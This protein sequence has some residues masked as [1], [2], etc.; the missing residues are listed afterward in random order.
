TLHNFDREVL[1]MS[2]FFD[3]L[4]TMLG[5]EDEGAV[6][7]FCRVTKERVN[8]LEDHPM[9]AEV[10]NNPPQNT[11]LSQC[12]KVTASYRLLPED[13][14]MSI[15]R[16]RTQLDKSVLNDRYS[17]SPVGTEGGGDGVSFKHARKSIHEDAI[18]KV[19]DERY[20]LD[21]RIDLVASAV[22][23]LAPVVK[24]MEEHNRQLEE[25]RNGLPSERLQ[26]KIDKRCLGTLHL[27]A[28]S[29]VYG[30]GTQEMFEILRK[31]PC[32]ALPV[33]V[34]RLHQKEVEWRA[35]RTRANKSW[36][37]T[38]KY[39]Y[40]KSLDKRSAHQKNE[41]KKRTSNKFFL[42]DIKER[43]ARQL[44]LEQ[45]PKPF[46]SS[47]PEP[48]VA[49]PLAFLSADA[50]SSSAD[51]L[52]GKAGP[53]V[54]PSPGPG[55]DKDSQELDTRE[56][57][58]DADMGEAGGGAGVP[59]KEEDDE[60]EL[61]GI[62]KGK[63]KP[64]AQF[65][66]DSASSSSSSSKK[67]QNEY[68][69]DMDMEAVS[70]EDKEAEEV[71]AH[72][73]AVKAA[74]SAV[75]ERTTAETSAPHYMF[76]HI[77]LKLPP[78]SV[79]KDIH[80]LIVHAVNCNTSPVDRNK[81]LRALPL[82]RYWLGGDADWDSGRDNVSEC[83]QFKKMPQAVLLEGEVV[84]T[85]TPKGSGLPPP[86]LPSFSDDSSNEKT[87]GGK[88]PGSKGAAKGKPAETW[89]GSKDTKGAAED[90]GAG[91]SAPRH[92]Q[93]VEAGAGAKNMDGGRPGCR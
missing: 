58:E 53:E 41:D 15:C 85:G 36:E 32:G 74:E 92:A 24:E 28:I 34:R 82:L 75:L 12:P 76:S 47:L 81:V 6:R 83:F 39:S 4:H 54:P 48:S 35:F 37:A 67:F 19:E 31:N 79:Q 90:L 49:S 21:M 33:I 8:T 70:E 43:R 27:L 50:A 56:T 88:G 72:G 44:A 64:K 71:L 3:Q 68:E 9:R 16:E 80:Q 77:R 45:A 62:V 26:Y 22:K 42:A 69:D 52:R 89:E 93:G 29:K 7:E 14:P 55:A 91:P 17:S 38:Q 13:Y 57:V 78:R 1:T 5:E 86:S 25:G 73:N 65:K 87:D 20:E 2:E 60:E 59:S 63:G 40:I 10:W 23:V 66:D 18:F 11:D 51:L 30:D 61:E 46:V 84:G